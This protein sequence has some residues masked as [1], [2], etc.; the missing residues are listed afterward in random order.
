GWPKPPPRPWQKATATPFMGRSWRW[1]NFIS[2]KSCPRSAGCWPASAAAIKGWPAHSAL[3]WLRKTVGA[4][5]IDHYRF[6]IG[7]GVALQKYPVLRCN[8]GGFDAQGFGC[9]VFYGSG[10]CPC[11]CAGD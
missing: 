6:D 9:W 8:M 2:P 10:P 1:R 4:A 7:G 11:A 3:R 5:P